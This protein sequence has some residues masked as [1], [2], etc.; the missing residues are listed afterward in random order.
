MKIAFD[1][2]L[3]RIII[4]DNSRQLNSI[5]FNS[6]PFNSTQSYSF[7]PSQRKFLKE[8]SLRTF[9]VRKTAHSYVVLLLVV[10]LDLSIGNN[11][12][13]SDQRNC[14][15]IEIANIKIDTGFFD[16]KV[17]RTLVLFCF[18]ILVKLKC[19]DLMVSRKRIIS[20]VNC[21]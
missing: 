8:D 15:D 9:R 19:C 11:K 12:K 21:Q 7:Y 16:L 20:S 1:M 3:S 18:V 13:M 2:V 10:Q 5:Q 4:Q 6:I 17:L 14:C